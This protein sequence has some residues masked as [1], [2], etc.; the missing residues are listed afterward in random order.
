[1]TLQR[2]LEKVSLIPKSTQ[3]SDTDATTLHNIIIDNNDLQNVR[4]NYSTSLFLLPIMRD[5]FSI[6]LVTTY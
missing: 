3:T 6:H 4:I 1:M 2:E 5:F